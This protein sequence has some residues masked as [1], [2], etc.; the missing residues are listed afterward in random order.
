[1]KDGMI[2]PFK[3][4]WRSRLDLEYLDETSGRKVAAR[5]DQSHPEDGANPNEIG[6]KLHQ[7]ADYASKE[8]LGQVHAGGFLHHRIVLNPDGS[9][10][11]PTALSNSE[12][13]KRICDAW[14]KHMREI[15]T[16]SSHPVIQHRLVFTMSTAFHD[17][18]VAAGINPDIVLRSSLKTVLNRF[19]QRFHPKDSIGYASSGFIG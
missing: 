3:K 6:K 12:R 17:K 13:K 9:R 19:Q 1:M 11:S 16:S 2:F 5:L 14:M 15:K 10:T 4:T 18:L 7:F 8:T